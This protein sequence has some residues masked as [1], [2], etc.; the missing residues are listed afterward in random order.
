MK[1][2]QFSEYFSFALEIYNKTVHVLLQN[3]WLLYDLI[4]DKRRQLSV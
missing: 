2:I 4:F 3:M 1:M